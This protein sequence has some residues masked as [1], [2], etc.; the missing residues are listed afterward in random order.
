M[1]LDTF[2]STAEAQVGNGG[3][4]Y[5][6]WFGS[7]GAW[8]AMFVSWCANEAD[9]L[10]TATTA[11]PPEVYKTASVDA[12]RQWYND[13]HRAFTISASE[14]SANYPKPGDIVTVWTYGTTPDHTHVGIVVE[15]DGNKITTIEGNLGSTNPI[16]KRVTYTD[17]YAEGFGTLLWVLSNHTSW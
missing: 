2:V 14:T 17:L 13:N 8:C 16:V 7:T 11:T 5:Q 10:T 1:S 15:T 9:I 4:T 3:S 12:M 6:N